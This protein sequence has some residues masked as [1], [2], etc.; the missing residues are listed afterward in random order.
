LTLCTGSLGANRNN[1][2]PAM[3][4]EFGGEGRVHFTHL[5]NVIHHDGLDFD[6]SAHLSRLG[7]LDMY[8]IV[9]AL[10]DVGFTGYMRPDHGRMI[11]GEKAR[12]GY[13]LYDRAIGAAYLLGL[14]EAITKQLR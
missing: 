12:P 14:Y 7:S 5:R 11:W 13:G 6:E 3:I 8:E 4:R 1:D 9:K 2:L 10:A